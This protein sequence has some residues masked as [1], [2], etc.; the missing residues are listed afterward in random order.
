MSPRTVIC[1]QQDTEDA[2]AYKG[3]RRK[4][5]PLEKQEGCGHAEADRVLLREAGRVRGGLLGF[6][7]RVE[8]DF[9]GLW[10]RSLESRLFAVASLAH[11]ESSDDAAAAD[12]NP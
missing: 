11:D 6:V 7:L 5:A 9:G 1:I 8:F 4:K 10:R 12:E 3:P 2:R